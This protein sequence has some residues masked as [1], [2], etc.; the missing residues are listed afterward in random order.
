MKASLVGVTILIRA[1]V[2]SP[3]SAFVLICFSDTNSGVDQPA[4]IK[5]YMGYRNTNQLID[6]HCALGLFQVYPDEYN[7]V[8]WAQ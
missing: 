7:G 2:R 4:V 3:K 1:Q 5:S 8:Q 6:S